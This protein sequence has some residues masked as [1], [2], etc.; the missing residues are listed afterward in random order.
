M[1]KLKQHIA[2]HASKLNSTRPVLQ[3]SRP[4]SPSMATPTLLLEL[5]GSCKLLRLNPADVTPCAAG[6][7]HA[8]LCWVRLGRAVCGLRGIREP[9]FHGHVHRL[10]R[11]CRSACWRRAFGRLR[12]RLSAICLPGLRLLFEQFAE[13]AGSRFRTQA[14]LQSPNDCLYDCF[15][16]VSTILHRSKRQAVR[17]VE[18]ASLS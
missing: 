11:P 13:V 14:M 5:Q 3:R 7:Q 10:Q 1:P 12:D 15:C 18:H 2:K 6:L 16:A 8:L 4:Q 17:L 9:S